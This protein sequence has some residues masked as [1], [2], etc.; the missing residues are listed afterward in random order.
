MPDKLT[1]LRFSRTGSDADAR[2]GWLNGEEIGALEGSPFGEFSRG[3]VVSAL[4]DVVLL[5]PCQPGKI[6]CV[7]RNYPAQVQE[8]GVEAPA[9]PLL[10]LKP[11]S[12]LLGH[13]GVI[14]LP[15]QSQ[16]V[17][18]EAELAVVI[19]KRARFVAPEAATDYI[20]GY[21]IAN[22]VTA[23]DLQQQDGQ[24]TRAKG[25]DT[26]CPLGPWIVTGLDPADRV[27]YCEVNGQ[28]RQM[29]ATREMVFPIPQLVAFASGV[30]TLLP[31]DVILTGTPAGVGPL[32]EG[33][34]VVVEI[35]GIGRLRNTVQAEVA[36]WD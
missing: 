32:A 21:T 35:E 12:S 6:L 23:R 30:M 14:R 19:G 16:Q 3:G 8:A 17:E 33:D 5:P 1:F 11:P 29:G 22:D 25:F 34:E 9:L 10:F 27:I 26:F 2:Y 20:F 7:G 18:H 4:A 24:W 15:A 36:Q 13:G 28:M 31:G